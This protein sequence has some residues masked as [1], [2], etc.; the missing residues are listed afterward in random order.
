MP[1]LVPPVLASGSLA[2]R[3]QPVLSIDELTVRPWQEADAPAISAAY[4]DPAIRHW[5][6]RSMSPQ[7]ALDWT[8]S[9]IQRWTLETGAGWAIAEGSELLG[10]VSLRTIDLAEGLAEVAYWVLPAARGRAVA[11]RALQLL[12]RWSLEDLGLHRLELEHST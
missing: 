8:H 5:H 2:A 12:S 7:E 10:R 11:P 6:A 3:T 9:W 4:D 1:V